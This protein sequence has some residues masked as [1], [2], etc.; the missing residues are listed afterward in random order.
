M[1]RLAAAL[2]V[3]ASCELAEEAARRPAELVESRTLRASREER[4]LWEFF[5]VDYAQRKVA[6]LASSALADFDSVTQPR[7]RLDDIVSSVGKADESWEADLS[8]FGVPDRAFVFRF[9]RLGLATPVSRADKEIFWTAISAGPAVG[10]I[11]TR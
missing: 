8:A 6:H 11:R 10:T 4:I 5:E 3:I 7:P 2:L 1:K 9:G